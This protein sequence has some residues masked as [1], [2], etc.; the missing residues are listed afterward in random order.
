M[1]KFAVLAA[2]PLAFVAAPAQAQQADVYVGASAGYHD[3][4]E[5]PVLDDGGFIFGGVVGVDFPASENVSIG[6]EGNYHFGTGL[7]DSEYGVAGRLAYAFNGGTKAYVRGGYQEV[8]FD[9]GDAIDEIDD[10]DTSEGDYLVGA[11]LEF[12]MGGGGTKLRVGVDTIAFD[13]TRFNAALLF[14]F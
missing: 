6:V 12:G 5:V 4:G 8:D 1:K 3:I 7:I 11:G 2:M 10:V 13:S 14:G 9:L